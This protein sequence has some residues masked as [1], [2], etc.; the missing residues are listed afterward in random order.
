VLGRGS[1]FVARTTDGYSRQRIC[2]RDADACGGR[3]YPDSTPRISS[4][5]C[6]GSAASLAARRH[7]TDRESSGKVLA[8]DE[9][10]SSTR[11]ANAAGR[12]ERV[13]PGK[14]L[15]CQRRRAGTASVFSS[16]KIYIRFPGSPRSPE[17]QE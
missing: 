2:T 7:V 1:R 9:S 8:K 3:H 6:R 4:P 10:A 15:P 17:S 13:R 5:T 16:E 14:H 12:A 11:H